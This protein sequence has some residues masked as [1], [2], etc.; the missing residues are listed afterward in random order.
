MKNLRT[1]RATIR[2]GFN[3]DLDTDNTPLSF[4]IYKYFI[5]RDNFIETTNVARHFSL[6]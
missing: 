5:L 2:M 6:L 4:I 1:M 3:M